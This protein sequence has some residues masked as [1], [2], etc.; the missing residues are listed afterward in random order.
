MHVTYVTS[1]ACPNYPPRVYVYKKKIRMA[2]DKPT[3]KRNKQ[4]SYVYV[5]LILYR[6]DRKWVNFV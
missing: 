3:R 2:T 6:A 1:L 5:Y 4:H